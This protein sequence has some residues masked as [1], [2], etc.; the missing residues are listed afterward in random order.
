MHLRHRLH[1]EAEGLLAVQHQHRNHNDV[2]F[3]G[4]ELDVDNKDDADSKKGHAV[5]PNRNVVALV[6]RMIRH[7]ISSIRQVVASFVN[8]VLRIIS[9][10]QQQQR[11]NGRRRTA[12]M[13]A[14]RMMVVLLAAIILIVVVVMTYPD[15]FVGYNL[16]SF[17]NNEPPASAAVAVPPDTKVSVVIMNHNRPRMLQESNLLPT[18]IAH[19]N[20]D[21]ILLCH[22]NPQTSF[23]YHDHSTKIKNI[24]AV[25]ANEDFGLSLRFHYCATTARNPWVIM[26]DDDQEI[27]PQAIT[28]LV[29]EFAR[30]PHRIVGRYGRAY[31]DQPDPYSHFLAFLSSWISSWFYSHHNGYS[32]RDVMGHVEVVLTKFMILE[33]NVCGAFFHY[34][35]LILDDPALRQSMHPFWNGEDIFM[36][37][38]ANHVY[39]SR[40][41]QQQKLTN[42]N[43]NVNSAA[44]APFDHNNYALRLP[45]WEAHDPDKDSSGKQQQQVVQHDISGNMDRHAIW[46]VGWTAYWQARQKAQAHVGYRGLLWS[47][48]KA[49]LAA[50][51]LTE[52][53]RDREKSNNESEHGNPE[54]P[55][56]AAQ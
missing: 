35:H 54:R 19:P 15:R 1:S 7:L 46:N 17:F 28:Q 41:Q 56:A 9:P 2:E 38:T 22:S 24:N 52:E 30:N 32:T 23:D 6:G 53:D 42:D 16:F 5:R 39:S 36:S 34:Q 13:L 29:S 33:Q 11:Y 12:S 20:I 55:A 37:L 14:R 45:V 4:G 43:N 51:S 49:R 26:V 31:H 44:A 10:Q 25:Q 18:L 3:Q 47:S 40:H 27:A 8:A 48:A 50:S 21:E